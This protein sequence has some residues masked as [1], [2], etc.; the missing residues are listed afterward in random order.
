L[1][2]DTTD[3]VAAFNEFIREFRNEEGD[4]IYREMI[5]EMT[6][7]G[8]ISLTVDFNDVIKFNPE[9]ARRTI[10][11]PKEFIEAGNKAVAEVIEIE[12]SD[13]AFTTRNFFIR[14]SNMGESETIPLRE[15]RTEHVGK[16]IM[17]T[18]II[19]RAT[20]VKPLLVEGF[21][22][23]LN[24]NEIIIKAQEESRYNPPH[25]CENP[26]CGRA[27]P[28]KL[29][30]E[31]SKF[32]DWQKVTI[33]ERPEDLPPG[34][35]P[36]SVTIL[37]TN[38]L[39]DTVRPG[40]RVMV[41]GV[42]KSVP[43]FSQKTSGKL[44]TFHINMDANNINPEEKEFD[45]IEITEEEIAEII[46]LSR[47]P[48][49]HS[50]IVESIAPSIYGNEDIKESIALLLFGG[51][52]KV[53]PDGLKIRGES[54]I[55]MIGDPGTAKS[56]ILRYVASLAPRSLYTSGKGTSA[57][58]LTVAVLRDTDTGEFTL[59]AGA[60]VLADRGIC[61]IDELDKMRTEDRSSIHEALEQR[62]VSVAKAGIVATLNARC[63]ILAAA[64]PKLGRYVASRSA[65]ENI[66]LPVTILSR[67][68]LIWIVKDKP[69]TES[70]QIKAQHILRLHTAGVTEREPPIPKEL[71]KKYISYAKMNARPKLSDD[72]A[73]RLE[74]YYLEMRQA[75]D[76]SDSPIAITARQLESLIRLTESHA[77]I[78]LRA[79]AS[80][81]DADAAIRLLKESLR[82]VGIDPETGRADIDVLMAGTSTSTR[83]RIETLMELIEK[84][85]KDNNNKAVA[86][87]K[88][89]EQ[90]IEYGMTKEFVERNIERMRQDGML[91]QPKAGFIKKT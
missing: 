12:D 6:V 62:T 86:I 82:Q 2:S 1:V 48:W 64:N 69:E 78:A 18:G 38:D 41:V 24:C 51:I 68:D 36:R 9:L 60:L 56:Q 88:I 34:Q 40:D 74:D 76:T 77:R 13:Y 21:F 42:L 65:A 3:P 75:G 27:G 31:E 66:N 63:S 89:I 59:E 58:G 49:I 39:V 44:A 32:I 53:L 61:C 47:D 35:M 37:L 72:A 80:V 8:E 45:H 91:F 70:D 16:L 19:T 20:V 90:A 85:E 79:E 30:T 22:Q 4:F 73:K 43:D 28:F 71:L 29:L 33:Q 67:F 23:C 10:D 26:G 57:A 50:K 84:M 5:Q 7:E 14:F 81:E 55:L 15:I 54:N 11:E 52:P 25:H 46:E 87:E 17:L 83:N